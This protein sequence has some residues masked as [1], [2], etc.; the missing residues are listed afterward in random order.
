M[1]IVD[2]EDVDLAKTRAIGWT[3]SVLAIVVVE[4]ETVDLL[5]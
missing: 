5:Q 4:I 2:L 1:V 3:L